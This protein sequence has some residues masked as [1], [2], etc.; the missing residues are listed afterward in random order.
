MYYNWVI[1]YAWMLQWHY[2]VH[3]PPTTRW[4][5]HYGVSTAGIYLYPNPYDRCTPYGRNTTYST[6]H[7]PSTV[8][9]L[10]TIGLP[11]CIKITTTTTPT[12]RRLGAWLHLHLLLHLLVIIMQVL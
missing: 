1:Q 8:P 5:Q 10:P 11:H 12:Y 9:P 2:A 7:A 3:P 6:S 4:V